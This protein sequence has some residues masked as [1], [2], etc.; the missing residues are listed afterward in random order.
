MNRFRCKDGDI[1]VIIY[2]TPSCRD[3]IGRFVEVRG[4]PRFDHSYDL[5]CWLIR[6]LNPQP[7]S[8]DE[9]GIIV[10]EVVGWKSRV[11]HPD[12]WLMP[13]RYLDETI[14]TIEAYCY[15]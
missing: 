6:P 5:Y 14:I 12:A 2:D 9:D 1:A 7:L 11:I 4:K 10:R 8:V 3:N 15:Q 13:V